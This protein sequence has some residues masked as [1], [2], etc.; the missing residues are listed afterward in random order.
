VHHSIPPMVDNTPEHMD[1]QTNHN[2]SYF[3]DSQ[4][5]IPGAPS[6]GISHGGE[7]MGTAPSNLSK[8][9]NPYRGVYSLWECILEV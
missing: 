2:K 9:S 3:D 1:C 4:K 7:Y 6:D 8:S 5:E